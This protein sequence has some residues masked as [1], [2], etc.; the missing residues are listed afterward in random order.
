M[1]RTMHPHT[2]KARAMPP[3]HRL[4]VATLVLALAGCASATR[5]TTP[6]GRQG[7]TVECSGAMQDWDACFVRADQLCKEQGYDLFRQ[8]GEEN[9]LI[10]SE[11]SHFRAHPTTHRTMVIACR[12]G[13]PRPDV[14]YIYPK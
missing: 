2:R 7:Y 1:L 9:A 3:R 4:L 6:D 11:P 13:T 14:E 8:A 10:A 5:M 12:Q